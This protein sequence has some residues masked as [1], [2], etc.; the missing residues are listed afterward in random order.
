MSNAHSRI[1]HPFEEVALEGTERASSDEESTASADQTETDR[2]WASPPINI[3]VSIPLIFG[4]WYFTIVGGPERRDRT[5]RAKERRKHPLLTFGNVIFFFVVGSVIGT[6]VAVL[7]INGA[8][9]LL[10]GSHT[11]ITP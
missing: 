8:V 9:E 11:V 4:R 1:Q 6:A 7:M 5:R 10:D 3:R 2:G